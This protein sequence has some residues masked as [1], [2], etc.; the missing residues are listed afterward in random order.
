MFEI[1][2]T[3]RDNHLSRKSR[4]HKEAKEKHNMRQCHVN[5]LIQDMSPCYCSHYCDSRLFNFDATNYNFETEHDIRQS[6]FK[7]CLIHSY[8]R[9]RKW[10]NK[11]TSMSFRHIHTRV[12]PFFSSLIFFII[13]DTVMSDSPVKWSKNIGKHG[14]FNKHSLFHFFWNIWVHHLAD[15]TIA[16]LKNKFQT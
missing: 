13:Y 4:S 9:R 12:G 15:L 2:L 10:N 7:I 5:L 8:V 11:Y 16:A 1:M 3:M 6:C 14:S